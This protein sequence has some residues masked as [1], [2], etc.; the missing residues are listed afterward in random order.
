MVADSYP[1]RHRRRQAAKR[2]SL[3]RAALLL[4]AERGIYATRVEDITNRAD[5][6]KG[7]FYNYFSSKNELVADLLSSGIRSL[8]ESYAEDLRVAADEKGRLDV[9]IRGHAGFFARERERALLFHQARGLLLLRDGR[10][11]QVTAIFS[12]YLHELGSSIL[13]HERRA[14]WSRDQLIRRG[15]AVAGGV[16]GFQSYEFSAGLA[17]SQNGIL[18]A[19]ANSIH[20]LLEQAPGEVGA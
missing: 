7:A 2:E 13:E 3:L 18:D 6:A 5:V 9:V 14:G 16:A 1:G 20:S 4:F 17:V 8:R 11:P 10:D 19:L 12:D 15:A